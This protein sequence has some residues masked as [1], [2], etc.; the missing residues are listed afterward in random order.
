MRD[1]TFIDQLLK[2]PEVRGAFISPDGKWIAFNW[3]R[4]NENTD[5]FVV[6]L[7]GRSQPIALTHTPDATSFVNWAPDSKSVLV[8]EDKD[9]DEFAQ[10]YRVTL[11]A[12]L[13]MVSL[14]GDNPG[15][16]PRGGS[17]VND[18]KGLVFGA[19]YDFAGEEVIEETCVYLRDLVTG[20]IRLLAHPEKPR[21]YTIAANLQ[22]TM[23]LYDVKGK[24]PA[25]VV[26]RLLDLVSGTDIEWLNF[27]DD[28][29]C[30]AYWM[31]DGERVAILTESKDG[32]AQDHLSVG[33]A[34]AGSSDIT[35]LV[36]DPARQIES[37][38]V[39]P[40]GELVL[41]ETEKARARSS[42]LDPV[43][44]KEQRFQ[45]ERGNLMVHGRAGAGHWVGTYYSS[46]H[47]RDLV[48]VRLEGE[49]VVDMTSYTNSWALTD[50]PLHE[51][52][53]AE[54][55]SWQ[56]SDGM[57]IHGWLYRSKAGSKAAILYIHGGPT[58]HTEDAINNQVQAFVR[59]GFNVLDVNY[60]GSTGHGLAYR[61]AIKVDGW[62][63][64]EQDD[65]A[66][67]AQS[68][69]DAGLAEPGRV[70]VT[71]TSYGGYSSWCQITHTPVKVIAAAVP[72]C[73]MTDLVVD[74]ETTRPDLRPY[75]A[76]MLGG[77][78][79][80][81][82]EKYYQRSPINYTQNIHGQLLIVQG[83]R[84]PN[85]TPKNVDEVVRKLDAQGK[86][87]ELLVFDDEGH[88]IGKPANQKVLISRMIAFF[89]D[90]LMKQE[91]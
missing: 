63:G 55:Y 50:L 30:W 66:A 38:R 19:N 82:P 14:T 1:N 61:E 56:S 70:G 40:E 7:E 84:D 49:Q 45:I 25:G 34:T 39:T 28:K 4:K 27:G 35:W 76:E 60:R 31:P 3:L 24:H 74:Y 65:I 91:D 12:P 23:V 47:P 67:G 26:F 11:D 29:K 32:R 2:T 20:G 59:A 22:G 17:L 52:A 88:G 48:C 78:P 57:T 86:R 64:H 46:T 62:G 83:A 71:G 75:S 18:S 72:I 16:F 36:D 15:Y 37:I 51:L 73:G 6:A 79:A 44:G 42:V 21:T 5:V 69:I 13:T 68:L 58:S 10:I 87:Y 41:M 8:A 9:G 80:E 89:T 85:V 43:T 54:P 33:I 90:V 81:L 77:T 53:A